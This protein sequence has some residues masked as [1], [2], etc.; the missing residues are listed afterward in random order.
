MLCGTIQFRICFTSS[1]RLH[2]I[3]SG[4][5]LPDV[6]LEEPVRQADSSRC[7]SHP[8]S[9]S[10]PTS[11]PAPKKNQAGKKRQTRGGQPSRHRERH[12]QTR[13]TVHLSH[14]T[15]S[16]KGKSFIPSQGSGLAEMGVQ[17]IFLLQRS[18]C[19]TE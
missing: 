7:C 18:K 15:S 11:H 9:S 3:F 6:R 13:Q 5:S 4:L 14:I 16:F 19:S 10:R 12:P 1:D 8:S 2:P 17:N